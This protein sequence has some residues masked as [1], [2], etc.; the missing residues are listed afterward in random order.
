[1]NVRESGLGQKV[2]KYN[3]FGEQVRIQDS[4]GN[5]SEFRY[6]KIGRLVARV[7]TEGTTAWTYDPPN[8]IGE[9][10]SISGINEFNKSY[11]YNNL[12]L[13]SGKTITERSTNKTYAFNYTYDDKGR[14]QKLTYPEGF[15]VNYGYNEF[16]YLNTVQNAT[17]GSSYWE[18]Q[19][20]N[21]RGQITSEKFGNGLITSRRYSDEEGYLRGIITGLNGTKV[22]DLDYTYD[23]IGNM[24]Q[25]RD[26]MQ[27]FTENFQYDNLNRLTSAF[28]SPSSRPAG[29]PWMELHCGVRRS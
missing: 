4:N 20:L 11:E 14:L 6:D 2:I 25:R 22:Q 7:S 28:T 9:V 5:T 17:D 13:L 23:N 26:L 10:A 27:N 21:E 3:A 16:E 18:L 1:M 15:A 12:G 24:D 8:A 29:R 19:S